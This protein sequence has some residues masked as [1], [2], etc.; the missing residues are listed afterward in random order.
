MLSDPKSVNGSENAE[1]LRR[2]Y[3]DKGNDQLPDPVNEER[4]PC[5]DFR[6]GFLTAADFQHRAKQQEEDE[7]PCNN[8]QPLLHPHSC[9]R[10]LSRSK[11]VTEYFIKIHSVTIIKERKISDGLLLTAL[12]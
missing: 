12:L 3:P 5:G 6:C 9:N 8:E 7:D 11:R 4:A 1:C 2:Q 10:I